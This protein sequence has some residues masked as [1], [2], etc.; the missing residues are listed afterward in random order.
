MKISFITVIH[1]HS[2]EMIM[3]MLSSLY[4]NIR[5]C[6][7]F[8]SEVLLYFGDGQSYEFDNV[9]TY[10]GSNLGYCG[11]NN[12]LIDQSTG[13][14]VIIVNPDVV[15]NN[16]LCFDWMIGTSRLYD[17]ISGKLNGTKEWYTYPSS[18][19]TDKKYDPKQLPF[20]YNEDT[21]SKPGNW[22][23]MRYIDGCLMCFSRQLYNDVG[24]FDT[25][26]FPGYFGENVFCFNAFLKG[27]NIHPAH[28]RNLYTHVE[29]GS[30]SSDSDKIEWARVAREYFYEKYAL[31]NWSK[32]IEYL[33]L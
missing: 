28:V 32:F 17:C 27:Y 15:F 14:Y 29:D 1:N 33:N 7:W 30:D 6:P 22:K 2:P 4:N 23:P 24:G 8:D 13:D 19:P 20:Y 12:Y 31:P 18:F 9:K 26:I 10:T 21:L 25:N 3:R 5:Y 11:G 16:S